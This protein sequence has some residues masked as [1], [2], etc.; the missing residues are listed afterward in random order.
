MSNRVT[1][2][3][4][5]L[6]QVD[7]YPKSCN[8]CPTPTGCGY[9]LTCCPSGAESVTDN[10]VTDNFQVSEQ[11]SPVKVVANIS[12]VLVPRTCAKC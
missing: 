5:N 1:I 12:S 6:Q 7:P 2:A 11:V 3:A 9:G 10:Y 4:P 8:N